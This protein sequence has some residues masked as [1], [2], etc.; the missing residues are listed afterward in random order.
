MA[1]VNVPTKASPLLTHEGGKAD[2]LTVRQ[3]L[4]R[5]VLTCMLWENSGYEDGVSV[6]ERIKG[7]VPKIPPAEVAALAKEARSKMN[8]RHVPLLLVRE[9]AR[10]GN[11][12]LVA[13]TLEEVIQRAD[14]LAE[15]VAIYWKDGKEPLSAGVKRGLARAFRKFGAYALAKYNK[16]A[17]IKLRDVLFLCHA[18][19]KDEAQAAIW[20]KLVDKTLESPDTWEVQLSAGKDKKKTFTRLLEEGKLGGLAVLRNLRNMQ[21]AGVEDGRIRARLKE[22]IQRAFPYRFVTAAKFAP[23]L[24]DALEEAMLL[25][26]GEV[27][28]LPGST[29]LLVDVSGSMDWALSGHAGYVATTETTKIDVASGLAIL[30]REQCEQFRVATFSSRV[31]EVAPRRGFALRDAIDT[32]QGHSS[33]ELK[34]ALATL[35]SRSE[36]TN[37]DRLVVITD[38]QSSD[39]YRLPWTPKAY[40]INVASNINGVGYKGG[41]THLNGWSERVFDYIRAYEES[42]KK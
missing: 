41:W 24:E 34:A 32:S 31:V 28:K 9:L 29:G 26:L 8:L 18:K 16:D 17:D 22:G 21:Q 23:T 4:E 42:E 37:L 35:A 13:D 40:M 5:S 15:F 3:Q 11:G 33:T 1:R 7:L 27:E 6:A 25:A 14:E 38:E 2:R 36:W 39:G 10:K 30:L 12:R 20:K 19:P